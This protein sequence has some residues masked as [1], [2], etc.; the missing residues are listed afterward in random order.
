[1]SQILVPTL[2]VSKNARLQKRRELPIPGA[3]SVK[4]G[5][6]VAVDTTVGHVMLPGDLVIVRVAEELMLESDE[7]LSLISVKV[8]DKVSEGDVLAKHSTFWGLFNSEVKSPVSGIVEMLS[9]TT[10]HL[11]IRTAGQELKLDAYISG[12]VVDVEPGKAAIVETPCVWVQGIFGLGGERHGKLHLL[13]ISPSHQ[14][15]EN[16]L[17]DD[18]SGLVLCGGTRPTIGAINK[19]ANG[20]AVGFVTGGIDDETISQYLG[21][22]LGIALTGDEEV[23]MTLIITEGFGDIAMSQRVIDTLSDYEGRLVAINGATQVRAGAVRPEIIV[24][25][26]TNT[27]HKMEPI[28]PLSLEVGARVR[29]IRVPHFGKIGVVEELPVKPQEIETGAVTRVVRVKLDNDKL[30]TVPRAN[31]EVV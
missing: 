9:S 10:S 21:Y 5:D 2:Q 20:G 29:L 26:D 23:P 4:V 24:P 17:P 3:I 18:V 16:D 8:G 13:K 30:V 28:K 22:D 15:T 7:A 25:L 14:I 6:K 27:E 31:V 12:T 19:A 11:G 1:M